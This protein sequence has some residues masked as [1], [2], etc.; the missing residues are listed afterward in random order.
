MHSFLEGTI[1]L[2]LSLSSLL[3]SLADTIALHQILCFF[4]ER[5]TVHKWHSS[6]LPQ[7]VITPI[8]YIEDEEVEREEHPARLVN[9][10]IDRH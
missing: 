10:S 2:S 7:G 9:P 8:D 1:L 6:L 4:N 5:R 3:K